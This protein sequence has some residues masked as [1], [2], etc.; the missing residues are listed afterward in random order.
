MLITFPHQHDFKEYISI[1]ERQTAFRSRIIDQQPL[2]KYTERQLSDAL[3]QSLQ[4]LYQSWCAKPPPM[5]ADSDIGQLYNIA[6]DCHRATN[7]IV[8][9][10]AEQLPPAIRTL[11][12]T[13][14][15]PPEPR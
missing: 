15:P 12:D 7:P 6:V 3:W 9:L 11:L 5:P 8:Y 1:S 13:V 10:T 14:P 2:L 4:Q